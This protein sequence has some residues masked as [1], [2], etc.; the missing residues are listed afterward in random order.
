MAGALALVAA[1]PLS[2][3]V[4][5]ALEAELERRV[6]RV[7]S[8]VPAP[9][10]AIG[11]IADD[12]LVYARGFGVADRSTGRPVTP[13]TMFQIGSTSKSF[14]ATLLAMLAE[15]GLLSLDD[16]VSMHLSPETPFP[17]RD[18]V[19][20]TLAQVGA[21]TAGLPR[22]PP[23]L[24]RAHGDAPVLAFT[25]FELYQSIERTTL[26]FEPGSRWSYSN[27]GFAILGHALERASDTPYETLLQEEM[28]NRLGMFS[29]T[30]TLW[31]RF[32]TLLARPY[33]PN[34]T[35]GTLDDYTPWDPEAMSPAGGLASSVVDLAKFVRLQMSGRVGSVQ[36]LSED[37][38]AE[39]HRPRTRLNDEI[40]YGIG[41]FVRELDGV[42]RIIEHGGEVDGYTTFLGFSPEHGVGVVVLLNAGDGPLPDLGDWLLRSVVESR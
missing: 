38:L 11:V 16:P 3:Q 6:D 1:L 10:M 31:P 9:G 28:L 36:L 20:P 2:A 23:T 15:R 19:T 26:E 7:L 18:G 37:A 27:Y 29:T 25:H 21:H 17:S 5:P 24:R 12:S 4:T 33:Y 42:G 40:S 41:W 13:A 8:T 39:I 32:D 34:S 30:Q 14:T 35:T 22:D